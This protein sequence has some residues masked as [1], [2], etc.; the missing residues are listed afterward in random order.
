[1][2]DARLVLEDYVRGGKVM[3]LAT[4]GPDRHP[5]VNNL[6]Y[7]AML[8]PDRL[9]FISRPERVHCQNIRANPRVAGAILAIELHDPSQPVQGITFTAQAR[10][11]SV[12]GIDEQI[13]AFNKLVSKD[14]AAFNKQAAIAK[15]GA[16][17]V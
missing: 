8:R 11:L 5:Y 2:S 14:V 17:G 13:N 6:W 1:M 12:T 9:L 10:E 7:A 4:T 3:Q 16:V 15:L